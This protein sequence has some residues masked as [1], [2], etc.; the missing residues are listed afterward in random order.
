MLSD[1][2][3]GLRQG[4]GIAQLGSSL[5]SLRPLSRCEGQVWALRNLGPPPPLTKA[6]EQFEGRPVDE[7][8][9]VYAFGVTLWECV[10]GDQAW[11]ELDHPMQVGVKCERQVW[12]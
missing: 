9:D 6:P 3:R 11:V 10:T 2:P 7:K 4:V 12:V 8:V 1:Y 5:P